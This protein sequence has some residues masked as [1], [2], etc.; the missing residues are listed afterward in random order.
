[1]IA[2]ELVQGE[3]TWTVANGSGQFEDNS[4]P[5][6]NVTDLNYGENTFIWSVTYLGCTVTDEVIITNNMP[7]NVYAGENQFICSDSTTLEA[8][9]PN[10]GV[11]FWSVYSGNANISDNT[12]HNA[13]VSNL[14]DGANI[15]LWAVTQGN[16]TA[17]D[18]LILFNAQPYYIDAGA[19]EVVCDSSYTL[20]ATEPLF[21]G[22][23]SWSIYAGAGNFSSNSQYNTDVSGL[24][25]GVN[26]LV[27]T[28]NNHACWAS[29]T[30]YLNNQRTVAFA[31]PD[32]IVFENHTNLEGNDPVFNK[33]IWT[34]HSG[35]G[36]FLNDTSNTTNVSGISLGSNVYKWRIYNDYCSNSDNVTVSR[37]IYPESNFDIDTAR[38]CTPF[39]VDF[40]NLSTNSL[41]YLWEFGDDSISYQINP[42]HIYVNAGTYK[43]VLKSLAP[44]STSAI[45]DTVVIQVYPLPIA[46]F[47]FAPDEVFIPEQ[48]LHCNDES[49]DASRYQ[50]NFGDGLFSTEQHPNH[51]YE[52][53]GLYSVQLIV[54]S[55]N[56]CTDT[57]II[58]DAVT[59][60]ESGIIKFPTA[61]RP[62]LSG[63]NGGTYTYS[64]YYNNS[65]FYPIRYG[66]AEYELVIYNRWGIIVFQTSDINEGWDGYVNGRIA[67][68]DVYVWMVKGVYNNGTTYN[69]MGDVTIVY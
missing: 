42:S 61:F 38:G 51:L 28:I 55:D 31:G 10:P 54:W 18:T 50:W 39:E 57:M 69:K 62:D 35:S 58:N 60:N 24:S 21:G 33:G 59:V 14:N 22:T 32:Q 15:L 5:N 56:M 47:T 53:T 25:A 36:N 44:D 2:T 11:G 48:S 67:A 3:G 17:K 45:S 16:C 26:V 65:V 40:S 4:I 19:D 68:E 41:G 9:N 13:Q 37:Y 27:W 30:V 66:V 6:S 46:K 29:D 1:M 12:L 52:E 7:L 64:E 8:N 43:T 34:L 63:S 23:G 49:I 20:A